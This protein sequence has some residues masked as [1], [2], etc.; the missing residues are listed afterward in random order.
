MKESITEMAEACGFT[1]PAAPE[2]PEGWECEHFDGQAQFCFE[3]DR[4]I[5]L[6]T[7]R[8]LLATQ[9][10]SIVDEKDKDALETLLRD[11]YRAERE[12]P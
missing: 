3:G 9:G 11:I 4:H 2:L 6:E 1:E 8:A 12:K 5:S 7:I 10:L